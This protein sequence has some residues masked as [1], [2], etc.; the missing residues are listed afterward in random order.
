MSLSESRFLNARKLRGLAVLLFAVLVTACA[1]QPSGGGNVAADLVGSEWKLLEIQSMNDEVFTP[2][3]T[4]VYV[5]E[6]LPAGR[7]SMQVDCNRAQG[8]WQQDGSQLTFGEIAV[9]RAM[10]RPQSLENRFLRE[11][12]YVRSFVVEDGHLFLATMADGAILEFEP[13]PR[14]P[15]SD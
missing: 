2:L 5:I 10:C 11:L 7:V 12:G 14:S 6:F 1:S 15:V 13:A 3:V 8:S 4:E 9:T